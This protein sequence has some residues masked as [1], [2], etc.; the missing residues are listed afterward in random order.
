LQLAIGES[1]AP[2]DYLLGLLGEKV[3]KAPFKRKNQLQKP[4]H[5]EGLSPEES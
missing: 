4:V 1:S 3:E 2:D 5:G